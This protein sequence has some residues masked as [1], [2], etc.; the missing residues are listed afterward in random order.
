MGNR[1]EII[2]S[3][4][5]E[6]DIAC[7]ELAILLSDTLVRSLLN[8]NKNYEDVSKYCEQIIPFVTNLY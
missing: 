1:Q 8:V 4:V 2:S 7:E 5:T 3:S 6:V